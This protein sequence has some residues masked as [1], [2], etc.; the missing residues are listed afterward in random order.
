M[1]SG[2]PFLLKMIDDFVYVSHTELSERPEIVITYGLPDKTTI[3][4]INGAE[5]WYQWR[6]EDMITDTS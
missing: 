6:G 4:T 5:Y 1:A 2:K 3:D